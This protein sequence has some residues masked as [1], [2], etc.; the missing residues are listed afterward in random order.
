[1]GEEERATLATSRIG[2][3]KNHKPIEAPKEKEAKGRPGATE[4]EERRR[5]REV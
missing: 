1:M 4:G 2:M 3:K 5:Q